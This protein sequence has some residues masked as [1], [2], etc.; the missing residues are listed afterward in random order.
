MRADSERAG[1]VNPRARDCQ[2]HPGG[3]RQWRRPM[4]ARPRSPPPAM[5]A[6]IASDVRDVPD[7]GGRKEVPARAVSRL[8]AGS[9]R[10]RGLHCR[11]ADVRQSRCLDAAH[12]GRTDQADRGRVRQTDGGAARR[13]DHCRNAAGLRS[14]GVVRRG[15]AAKTSMAVVNKINAGINE[16]LHDPDVRKKLEN[17]NA[18]VVGGTQEA[19]AAYFRD[20]IARWGKVIKD[21]NVKVDQ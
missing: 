9:G 15:G 18:E 4:A 2:E 20:E 5:A 3:H 17:L 21:A 14:G 13:A 1:G 8:G 19:T 12:Q 6:R 7:D 16:A 11:H 10:S